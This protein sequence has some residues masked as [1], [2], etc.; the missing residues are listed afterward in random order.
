MKCVKSYKRKKC[1]ENGKI[2]EKIKVQIKN[3]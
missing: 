3:Q 1:W 2:K